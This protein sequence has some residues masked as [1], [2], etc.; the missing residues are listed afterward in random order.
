L[1]LSKCGWAVRVQEQSHELREF[2]AGVFLWENVLQALDALGVLGEVMERGRLCVR[3]DILDDRP[4]LL[5]SVPFPP[6]RRQVCIRRNDLYKIL[7]ERAV[8]SGVEFE[9][10]SRAVGADPDGSLHLADGNTLKAD[11]VVGSDGVHSVVRESL[12]LSRRHRTRASGAIR[13]LA[14]QTE[15]DR[16]SLAAAGG[17]V[18]R[19]YLGQ[20]Q[21]RVLYSACSADEVYIALGT[22]VG[23][24][25]GR[26]IPVDT[27]S[28]SVWFPDLDDIFERVGASGRWDRYEEVIVRKWFRGRV[29][30]VG[31]AAHAMQPHLGQGAC[32]AIANSLALAVCLSECPSVDL[33]LADWERRAR[34]ITDHAQRWS[35]WKGKVTQDEL[36]A[37]RTVRAFAAKSMETWPFFVREIN[38]VADST[39]V[40]AATRLGRA[41]G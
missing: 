8:A 11:L 24:A 22:T 4:V 13:L 16:E 40:G 41:G 6:T 7:L 5:K 19:H 10:D 2:G 33:G 31:D 14:P 39:P 32:L 23:D 30:L 38:K 25:T 17:A 12:G 28:W 35:N 34:P 1:A 36:R 27:V 9:T 15:A 20:C 26:A 18:T 3:Q 21:R 37:P 29:A